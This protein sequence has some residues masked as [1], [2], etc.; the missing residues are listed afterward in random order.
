LYDGWFLTIFLQIVSFFVLL[1][2]LCNYYD[3][4]KNLLLFAMLASRWQPAPF[5]PDEAILKTLTLL[6]AHKLPP[7]C[8]AMSSSLLAG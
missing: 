5:L 7:N 1:Q 4:K 2:L 3:L 6:M 8:A